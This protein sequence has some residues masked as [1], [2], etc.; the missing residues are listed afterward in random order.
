MRKDYLRPESIEDALRM[1]KEMGTD[2]AFICGGSEVN[3]L[4]SSVSADTVI[5]IAALLPSEIKR[6][7]TSLLIGAGVRLQ[8]LIDEDLCPALVEAARSAGSRPLRCMASVG[9]NIASDRSDSYLIP[10]LLAAD[11]RLELAGGEKCELSTWLEEKKGIIL[12][13]IL[14]NADAPVALAR[15]VRTAQGV[16]VLVAAFRAKNADSGSRV[17]IGGLPGSPR[18]YSALEAAVDKGEITG[19]EQLAD[20][21]REA[22]EPRKDFLGSADYKRYIAGITFADL[23]TTVSA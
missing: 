2:A 18:R 20:R 3:R 5:D 12:R 23:Y 15:I 4:K 7:G 8:E 13:V 19:A 17:V 1:Q 16:P 14:P 22:V 21:V 6:E 10:Y 11:A 9:G